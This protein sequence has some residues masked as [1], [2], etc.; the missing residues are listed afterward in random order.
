MINNFFNDS[1]YSLINSIQS[2]QPQLDKINALQPQLELIQSVQPKLDLAVSSQVL[3]SFSASLGTIYEKMDILKSLE[4]FYSVQEEITRSFYSLPRYHLETPAFSKL[5]EN[6]SLIS[7]SVD[8]P[9]QQ[10]YE[11]CQNIADALQRRDDIAS[12]FASNL[13]NISISS[14]SESNDYIDLPEPVAELISDIDDS[15]ELPSPNSNQVIRIDKSNRDTLF[16]VLG[17][18]LSIFS[19]F[20]SMFSDNASTALSKQQHAERIQQSEDQHEELMLE[21]QRQTELLEKIYNALDSM[22][23]NNPPPTEDTDKC[24]PC[25]PK[26]EWI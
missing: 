7:R 2:I 6:I 19:L 18:L 23:H 10:L 25:Q 24:V 8:L 17:L 21:E 3:R 1:L 5:V 16:A 22:L 13:E 12:T 14:E 20:Y 26:G 15:I 11:S 4:P 9:I